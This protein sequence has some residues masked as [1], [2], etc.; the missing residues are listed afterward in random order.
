MVRIPPATRQSCSSDGLLAVVMSVLVLLSPAGMPASAFAR[1]APGNR[2]G[3]EALHPS[4]RGA[5]FPVFGENGYGTAFLCDSAGLFLTEQRIVTG[6]IPP[7]IVISPTQVL[8]ARVLAESPDR[9]IAV[10]WV[11]PAY[12]AGMT[13]LPLAEPKA[14]IVTPGDSV[15]AVGARVRSGQELRRASVRRV[16]ERQ[17]ETDLP[18]QPGDVG[19]PVLNM[20]GEVI[21]VLLSDGRGSPSGAVAVLIGEALPLLTAALDSARTMRRPSMELLPPIPSDPYPASDLRAFG[22]RHG[23][24]LKDYQI[25]AAGYL[26]SILTPPICYSL[27]A[28]RSRDS[29]PWLLW[30]AFDGEYLPVVAVH[31]QTTKHSPSILWPFGAVAKLGKGTAHVFGSMVGTIEDGITGGGT[32][33][34]APRVKKRDHCEVQLLHNGD[35][36]EPVLPQCSGHVYDPDRSAFVPRKGSTAAFFYFNRQAFQ[37]TGTR[38]PDIALVLFD[39]SRPDETETV[40]LPR[41]IVEMIATDLGPVQRSP[42]TSGEPAGP[43]QAIFLV[44]LREGSVLRALEVKPRGVSDIGIVLEAG[45]RI[46]VAGGE[47]SS[48]RDEAGNDWTRRVVIERGGVPEER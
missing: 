42:V 37:S 8:S 44:K 33:P 21:G 18:P 6:S 30:G 29:D 20:N 7:R 9:R 36:V 39:P 1:D 41:K 28:H 17:I 34:I 10:L 3:G 27:E 32:E 24:D 46:F 13:V 14:A 22:G 38:P 48:I 47:V 12:V 2:A 43:H 23:A 16:G 31:I 11:N 35:S 19:G 15:D 26:I 25:A 45:E 5:V 40:Q 4:P